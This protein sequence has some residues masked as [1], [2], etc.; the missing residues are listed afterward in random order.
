VVARCDGPQTTWS[1][2]FEEKEER[3]K[4]KEV[5]EKR[6]KERKEEINDL[7]IFLKVFL[8]YIENM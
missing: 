4:R 1:L 2:Q 5:G 8:L 7:S 6:R 3:E